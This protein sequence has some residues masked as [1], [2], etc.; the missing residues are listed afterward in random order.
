MK[1]KVFSDIFMELT[2]VE[3]QAVVS[4]CCFIRF[5]SICIDYRSVLLESGEQ[6][7]LREVEVSVV[8]TSFSPFR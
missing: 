6:S 3:S 5:L 7:H 1:K 2:V 4:S 8:M